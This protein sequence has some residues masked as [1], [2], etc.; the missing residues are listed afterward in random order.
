MTAPALRATPAQRQRLR[1]LWRSAGW[2]SRDMLELELI[3]AGWVERLLDGEGRETLRLTD[4][5]I[6][7]LLD[8]RRRHQAARGAHEDLVAQVAQ[9]MQRDG[10]LAWRGLALRAPLVEPE[11]AGGS[12]TRWVVAMPDVYSIRHTTRE[13]ALLPIAHE[14]K[15][16]RADLLADLRRPAKAEAYR[17]LASECWYVLAAG[18]AQADEIPP[19][20]GVLQA[21]P[22]G[23]LEVL[24]P[25]PRRPFTPQLGLWMALARATP[26]P[27]DEE[28]PQAPLG[29][30]A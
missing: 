8:A 15:V 26:E 7:Q 2:P 29:P 21:T 13:D 3:G 27:P 28:S 17:A 19:L 22:G 16:S 9:A 20:F 24:R 10:R 11:A 23:A 30:V 12:R 4:A 25:A 14:V 5:G 18:I 6:A 1:A